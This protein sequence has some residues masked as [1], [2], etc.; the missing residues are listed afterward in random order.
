M[1]HGQ[2]LPPVDYIIEQMFP[3]GYVGS[4]VDVGATDGRAINNTLHFEERGWEVLCI[5]ANPAYEKALRANRK[6]VMRVA[7]GVQNGETDFHVVVTEGNEMS[8]LSGICV[9]EQL[10]A[11]FPILDRKVI[12]V[13]VRTLDSCLEEW[14]F[15]SVDLVSVDTEGTELDVLRGLDLPRWHPLVIVVEN[16]WETDDIRRY[17]TP[18]GYVLHTRHEVNDFYKRV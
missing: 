8:R 18:F 14:E 4:A 7:C 3:P 10:A 9:D 2:F 17:L 1:Y 5:E 13:P 11:Q 15:Q 16:N 12:R 6:N